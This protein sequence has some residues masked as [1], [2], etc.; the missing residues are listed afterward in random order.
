M[1]LSFNLETSRVNKKIIQDGFNGFLAQ[2]N[3][4][5]FEKLSLLIKNRRV[6]EKSIKAARKTVCQNYSTAKN[7]EKLKKIINSL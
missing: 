4:E 5:W 1:D 3:K 7:F 6:R 2:G